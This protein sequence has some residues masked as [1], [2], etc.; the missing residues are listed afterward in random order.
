MVITFFTTTK[1]TPRRRIPCAYHLFHYNKTYAKKKKNSLWLSP[2]SLQQN[3]RPEEEVLVVITF[4]TT[5]KPASRRRSP[6]GYHL[7]HYNKTYAKKKN[8]LCLSPFSLQQNLGKEEEEVLVVITFFTTTKPTPRRRSPCGYHLFHYNKTYAKKK[9]SLWLSPFSLQQ[10]LRQAEE[11]LVAITFFTTAKPTPRR[12]SPCGYH[13]FHYNKTY[14]RKK[15]SLWLSPFSLQQNLRQ[16]EEPTPRRRNPCAYH[17]F[18]YNKTYAKEEEEFLVVITFFTTTKPTPRRRSPCGYHLFHYNKTCVKKKKSLWLSPF[19]LQQNLRQE[20]E[21][22]VLITF[23]T[24]TKPRQRRR[25]SPCGYHLF[26]Y[27]KTYAKKKKSLWLSPFSLQQNLRQEEEVLVV[28][29][30]FTTT[31]PTPSRRSP[32]GYHLF[33]YS[34]TYAKKKKSLWLSPFSLQQNLR[35]EEEVLVV[36]TFFTTTKPTPS[37]RSPCGYH[38]FHYNKTYAKK[39]SLWLSPL[40]LQ[41]NLRQEEEEVLVVITFITTTK[42]TP[43]RRRSPCGYHLYH[44]NK[45]YAQKKKSLWL[46]P[47]SLQQNLR[48]EEEVLVA[49]T[50]FTT[51]K[52]TPRRRSPCGYHLFRYNKTYAKKK[53][54]WLSP[55]YL[56]QITRQEEEVLVVITF[57]TTTKPTPGRRSPCGYHLFH[58][59]KTYAKQKKS[60]WLSPFSLQQNLRQEE[61]ILV[62]ITFFTTTKPRQR[63]RRS[64]CGYHL[65]H[66]NKT[67]A[68]KKKSL[69]L[70]PFS[71]Q[72]NLRQ[73]EEFLVL[74]TF[75]TTTKPRQRR[76]RIPCGYH[77]FHYNKTYAQKKKSLWLSPFSLQQNLRQEEEVLVVITFFTTT[78]PTPR[79]RIPCAYHLF[80]YNKT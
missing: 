47:F 23:F 79:R 45:T 68:K 50:F 76:R 36:I 52:P 10:N 57:F 71:L 26:H 33:H 21:F 64:P 16:E 48:Q 40:S 27:Y 75:F 54:L 70:S 59:N 69:W 61:E 58:Y 67:Y 39:K 19:S 14:A 6:C 5:T 25:R 34:K 29:T 1:P 66:Y 22:L 51:P 80:H 42:P 4:F 8:S 41:Q 74:I 32:C 2:F 28:I 31:K 20:E 49:I 56:Q 43:R 37:R 78:K 12:R 73:E 44:Y 46:S 65:F 60:L 72:Q 24:T 63:R 30:F 11:V 9:K 15:K 53:C 13:L 38:L 7:F 17:L 3:L 55:F 77:L 18:H 35:Q 62:L